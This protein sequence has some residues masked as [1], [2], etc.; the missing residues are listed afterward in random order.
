M[1][2]IVEDWAG[3]RIFP[4]KEFETFEDGWDHIYENI[5]E[6]T[7]DDGTYDDYFVIEKED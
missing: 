7:E 1:A 4:D 3:N 6:E 2:F 5:Q